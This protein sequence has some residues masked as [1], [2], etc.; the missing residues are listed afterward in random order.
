[1]RYQ[2]HIA[3]GV[4]AAIA[5]AAPLAHAD[6]RQ[7]ASYQLDTEVRLLTEQ[8]TRGMS[9]SLLGPAAKLSL[10]FAHQSGLVAV[11][12]LVTVSKTQFLDGNG[13]GLTLGAG[14]RFGDPEGW[15]YGV[16]LAAEAFPGAKFDA[17]HGFDMNA[18]T[19]TNFSST[20]YDSQFAVLEIGYGAL[21]GRLLG[22]LSNTYR[23]ADTGGVC[24]AMLQFSA[25]PTKALEC[26]ARGDQG[27][28]GSLLF[29]LDYKIRLASATTLTLHVGRQ[30]V[31]NFS[32]A[33]FT[34]YRIGLT[35]KQWG[36]EWNL[37]WVGTQVTTPELFMVQ[38]G[39]D[40]RSVN[41]NKLLFSVARRF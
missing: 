30:R 11:A 2:S 37:D 20:K 12:E 17:P 27:S 8:R 7:T 19:P 21:E 5:A 29:D 13:M 41:N 36:F 35:R 40:V 15:H 28:R 38:D 24:G 31:A 3:A 25:D 39:N 34:D 6:E 14:Y 16:G 9:D 26:Y 23:G 22:V 33:D 18:F 10:Q 1:M 32:E 4:L